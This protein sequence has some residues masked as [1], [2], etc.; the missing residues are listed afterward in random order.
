MRKVEI[1]VNLYCFVHSCYLIGRAIP[2]GRSMCY[3]SAMAA[4]WAAFAFAFGAFLLNFLRFEPTLNCSIFESFVLIF[5]DWTHIHPVPLRQ[6]AVTTCSMDMGICQRHASSQPPLLGSS[7]RSICS[8]QP[9]ACHSGQL[10]TAIHLYS[11]I[12]ISE[13]IDPRKLQQSRIDV[14]GV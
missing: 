2:F 4:F 9:T 6:F 8:C 14:L 7:T 11:R 10:Q 5:L 1:D 12:H 3:R 13:P